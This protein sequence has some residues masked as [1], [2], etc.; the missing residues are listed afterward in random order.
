MTPVA[1]Q[2]RVVF[3]SYPSKAVSRIKP[4]PLNLPLE[5]GEEKSFA[6][7]F[8]VDLTKQPKICIRDRP[9][10]LEPYF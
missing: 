3:L 10:L 8:G 1:A 9:L 5:K 4:P 6:A 2:T 7:F